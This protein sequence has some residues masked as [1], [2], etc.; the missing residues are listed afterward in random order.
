MHHTA[1]L[2]TQRILVDPDHVPILQNGL[3]LWP[4]GS[5]IVGHDQRRGKHCPESHLSLRLAD[6]E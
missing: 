3:K 4:D 6:A 1:T 2:V 5:Q